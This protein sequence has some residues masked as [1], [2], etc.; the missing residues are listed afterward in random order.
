MILYFIF[1]KKGNWYP[2]IVLSHDIDRTRNG[3][4]GVYLCS[5]S[6]T[7]AP[8]CQRANAPEFHG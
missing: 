4:S 8:F 3:G 5:T 7:L 6:E 1:G 2:I